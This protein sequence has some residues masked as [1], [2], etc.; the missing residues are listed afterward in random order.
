MHRV[1]KTEGYCYIYVPF[2]YYYH[3]LPGYYQD[4]YRFTYDGIR[5]L[6]RDFGSVEI[7][8]VRGATE[9][10]LNLCPWFSKKNNYL[11]R[12][13]DRFLGKTF[14]KQT[15]GFNVFCVK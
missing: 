7:Q 5:Y 8:N 4:F 12:W 2:L 3:P 10:L 15:S 1:L 13:L 6:T 14:S 9:T 11:C